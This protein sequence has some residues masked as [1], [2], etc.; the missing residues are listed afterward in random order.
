[1][2]FRVKVLRL[3]SI[4]NLFAVGALQIADKPNEPLWWFAIIA[5]L[6]APSILAI[7]LALQDWEEEKW[8][9]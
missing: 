9:T 7:N 3:V 8:L 5:N 4:L 2:N 6:M 1:M